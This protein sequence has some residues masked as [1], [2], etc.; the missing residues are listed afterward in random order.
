[1]FFLTNRVTNQLS[2]NNL[3][4][5]VI[6]NSQ[7]KG[8]TSLGSN[9]LKRIHILKLRKARKDKQTKTQRIEFLMTKIPSKHITFHRSLQRQELTCYLAEKE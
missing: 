8:V 9:D 6:T 1:M 3:V 7:L 4:N 2:L 5:M